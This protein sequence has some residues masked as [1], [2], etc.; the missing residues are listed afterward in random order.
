MFRTAL[1]IFAKTWRQTRC[2][3][4]AEW[5]TNCDTSDELLFSDKKKGAIKPQKDMEETCV[6]LREKKKKPI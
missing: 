1:F 3:S 6:L 5:I 2:A 4:T